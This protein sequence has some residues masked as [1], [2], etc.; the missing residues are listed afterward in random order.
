MTVGPNGEQ[1]VY[2]QAEDSRNQANNGLY[3]MSNSQGPNQNK[4]YTSIGH[5]GGQNGANNMMA[6]NAGHQRHLSHSGNS[7]V[8]AMNPVGPQP[9]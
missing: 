4:H 7:R 8:A 6:P 5:P 2:R 9:G 3:G 1:M